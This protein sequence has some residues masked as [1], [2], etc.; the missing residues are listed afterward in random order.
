M[1]TTKS[2]FISSV[3]APRFWEPLAKFSTPNSKS[4]H[5]QINSPKSFRTSRKARKATKTV[6]KPRDSD[7]ALYEAGSLGKA[8][9]WARGWGTS[10]SSL[11]RNEGSAAWSAVLVIVAIVRADAEGVVGDE[12]K[13]R[14]LP[15]RPEGGGGIKPKCV[16]AKR[17]VDVFA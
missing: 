8:S 1:F 13:N 7:R 14:Q 3:L 12:T 2:T 11:S 6:R 17:P 9:N 16:A 10:W 4:G 15:E 5:P